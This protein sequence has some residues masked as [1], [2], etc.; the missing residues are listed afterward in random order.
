MSSMAKS[1]TSSLTPRQMDCLR[2]TAELK[3]S[4][5]IG[6]EL[7]MSQKTVDTHIAAA[8]KALGAVN[9]RDAARI[10]AQ[11]RGDILPD[12]L[13]RQ[14]SRLAD[15][16]TFQSPFS[17]QTDGGSE[18]PQAFQEPGH[19][20]PPTPPWSATG[21]SFR[22]FLEGVKPDDIKPINR[23]TLIVIGAIILALALAM[24]VTFVDVLSRLTDH[25]S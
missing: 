19:G 7:C 14:T 20:L 16:P 8:I 5:E 21:P 12:K 6:R 15:L 25:S 18:G 13:L 23:A 4:K 24:T 17:P 10:F 11:N 2:L 3:S 1:G 9:R 22:M